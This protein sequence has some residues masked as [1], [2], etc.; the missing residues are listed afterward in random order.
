MA[1]KWGRHLS[2]DTNV[3]IYSATPYED[4]RSEV[5][6]EIVNAL[7][8]KGAMLT[9]LS[10]TEF[11]H[12]VTER[13]FRVDKGKARAAAIDYSKWFEIVH[14]SLQDYHEALDLAAEN[15]P[16]SIWDA[17]H[18]V[19]LNRMGCRYFLTEDKALVK[20]GRYGNLEIL[21]PFD[22]GFDLEAIVNSCKSL[23]KPDYRA[24]PELSGVEEVP[25]NS[26]IRNDDPNCDLPLMLGLMLTKMP[27]ATSIARAT[28]E[29]RGIDEEAEQSSGSTSPGFIKSIEAQLLKVH[30]EKPGKRTKKRKP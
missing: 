2:L 7:T 25:P 20:L 9:T 10:L 11:F 12:V 4:F 16:I 8:H 23:A 6:E 19:T 5:A 29:L 14:N 21:S 26:Y 22:E 13:K 15:D 17:T 27:G 3:L 1:H 18:L 24:E 30:P 28:F